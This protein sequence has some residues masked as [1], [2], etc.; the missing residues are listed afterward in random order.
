[1]LIEN[2]KAILLD[3]I[4]DKYANEKNGKVAWLFSRNKTIIAD[5]VKGIRDLTKPTEAISQFNVARMELAREFAVKDEAGNPKQTVDANG[6]LS[7]A[8][9]DYGAFNHAV[10][11]LLKE[12]HPQA[13]IDQDAIDAKL[14]S[15]LEE[16][17]DINLYRM[18]LNKIPG[19]RGENDDNNGVISSGD[20][21]VLSELGIIYEEENSSEKEKAK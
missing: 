19:F 12:K 7:F 6:N 2:S 18:S 3:R 17:S 10:Q 8:I 4:C 11:T 9:K 1:M 20:L 16:K 15:I 14:V 13:K 5:L 21:A